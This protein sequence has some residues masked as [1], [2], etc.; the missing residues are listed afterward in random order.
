[1]RLLAFGVFV[2]TAVIVIWFVWL[3]SLP[4]QPL[5]VT[6]Q[7]TSHLP[8]GEVFSYAP[9]P[10]RTLA[11]TDLDGDGLDD[12][13]IVDK[14]FLRVYWGRRKR[15][16]LSEVAYLPCC[17]LR[18]IGKPSV[19]L[20]DL[21]GDKRKEV[22]SFVRAPNRRLALVAWKFKRQQ[23]KMKQ[24]GKCVTDAPFIINLT[25]VLDL[26]GDGHEEVVTFEQHTDLKLGFLRTA[27]ATVWVFGWDGRRFWQKK[28][29]L[30]PKRQISFSFLAVPV[31]R[32]GLFLTLM[33]VRAL[34][35]CFLAF[36]I[37]VAVEKVQWR[38]FYPSFY[39]F[40]QYITLLMQ[41]LT[42]DP[43][44]WRL[45]AEVPGKPVKAADLDGD[46]ISELILCDIGVVSIVRVS[47]GKIE[48]A[49]LRGKGEPEVLLPYQ[50][51][52]QLFVRW[53]SGQWQKVVVQK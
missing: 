45:I 18:M 37:L 47:K 35:S 9:L 42:S 40:E 27:K 22:V 20:V 29:T 25:E 6:C 53:G 14:A 21:D 5:P 49:T 46:G 1:M 19:Y 11:T 8:K 31:R 2:L 7:V 13:V 39:P 15:E 4:V 26:D 48:V 24:I 38:G 52:G 44:N 17:L 3:K 43:S 23:G 16:T 12:K 10:D 32:M 51:K 50:P 33:H 41:A 36:P 34:N 30:G 28:A